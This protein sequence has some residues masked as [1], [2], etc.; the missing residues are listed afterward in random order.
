MRRLTRFTF[1][2]TCMLPSVAAANSLSDRNYFHALDAIEVGDFP[3]AYELLESIRNSAAYADFPEARFVSAEVAINLGKTTEARQLLDGLTKTMPEIADY[4]VA[5]SASSWRAENRWA[6]ALPL[7]QSILTNMP[8]SPLA[9][10]LRYNIADAYY[11]LN[12][13]TRAKNA[14]D[15]AIRFQGSSERALLARF[16]LGRIAEL[17]NNSEAAATIYRG[18]MTAN[19]LLAVG[20]MAEQRL[21]A[22]LEHHSIPQPTFNQSL[23]FVDK[24]Y[25]IRKY[26]DALALIAK[27][28]S[29]SSSDMREKLRVRRAQIAFRQRNFPLAID[30]FK[31]LAAATS[32]KQRGEYL[33]S[34]AN[35]YASADRFPEAI[36]IL[37]N[38]GKSDAPEAHEA[39]FKAG[40]LAYNSG[41]HSLAVQ[42]F[43]EFLARFPRDHIADEATWYLA[44]NSYRMGDLQKAADTLATLRSRFPRSSMTTRAYY[45]E[46]R[47]MSQLGRTEDAQK[48]FKAAAADPFDYYAVIAEQRLNQASSH[49]GSLDVVEP[50][51]PW[52]VDAFKWDT[53][54]GQRTL[55]LTKLGMLKDAAHALLD[56]PL[57]GSFSASDV[58]YAKARI[59]YELGDFNTTYRL[60]A[61]NFARELSQLPRGR[62]H[63]LYHMAY[64]KAFSDWV[65]T[66]ANEFGISPLLVL[67]LMRQESAFDDGAR[68]WAS[69]NGLMQIIPVTGRRIAQAMGETLYSDGL[70]RDPAVNVRFGTWYLSQLVT[71]FDGNYVL[72]IGSY[73]AGPQA[74]QRWTKNRIQMPLD[75]FV[76]DI[77]YR[78]TRHY[79]KN[80]LSNLAAYN[81]L[82]IKKPISLPDK[83]PSTFL[84]NVNF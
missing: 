13:F 2:L 29:N 68:S 5:L 34:L 61:G 10:D 67:S 75:E 62:A 32:V 26:D 65:D 17:Q 64:P 25:N 50:Q 81:G 39:L 84:D 82:Y 11:A 56:V 14:Y 42:L 35:C 60:V 38:L 18:L 21:Q 41:N 30:L 24:L 51:M 59:L 6:D 70:L 43:S 52:G 37:R 47:I 55:R 63:W 16:N 28:E 31:Q 46:G 8:K 7:W 40:W 71:K 12:D 74:V 66:A 77:P 72:A 69:A 23:S 83:V 78:E 54:E 9:G 36:A 80:V 45:W 19:S 22:M 76:E 4:I 48:A 15:D 44:W 57:R 33:N 73:N 58:A 49:N 53:F 79:V 1:A 27:L 3:K 20:S